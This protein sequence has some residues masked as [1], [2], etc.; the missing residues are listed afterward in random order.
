M[1]HI[2]ILPLFLFGN[3]GHFRGFYNKTTKINSLSEID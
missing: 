1:G 3:Y 2:G